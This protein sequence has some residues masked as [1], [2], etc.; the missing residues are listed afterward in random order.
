MAGEG[1]CFLTYVPRPDLVPIRFLSSWY[2][3]PF[4]GWKATGAWS[5]SFTSIYCRGQEK[6]ELCVLKGAVYFPDKQK[7]L[8]V[9]KNNWRS[10]KY[11]SSYCQV[12][13]HIHLEVRNIYKT[14]LLFRRFLQQ[15]PPPNN[16]DKTLSL[17][18]WNQFVWNAILLWVYASVSTIY[19]KTLH[20][21]S[22]NNFTCNI[23]SYKGFTW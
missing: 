9:P 16:C 5:W 2:R 20:E 21:L 6:E 11:F 4:P 7:S 23:F 19:P 3:D 10:Q 15:L 17:V 22:S 12:R 14:L 1:I 18:I 8:K 13:L